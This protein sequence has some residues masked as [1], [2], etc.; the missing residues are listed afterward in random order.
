LRFARRRR[1]KGNGVIRFAVLACTFLA[2][3]AVGL[4]ASTA[5]AS[6]DPNTPTTTTATDCHAERTCPAADHSYVWYDE[7]G[8]GWDCATSDVEPAEDTRARVIVYEEISYTCYASGTAPVTT[9]TT[10]G[11][12]TTEETTTTAT[13]EPTT[14]ATVAPPPAPPAVPRTRRVKPAAKQP[15]PPVAPLPL[16]KPRSRPVLALPGDLN[17][18]PTAAGYV[19]PVYGP[20]S[21][22]DTYGAARADTGWHHG[23]DIFAPLG[24]PVLA[25][26]DGTVFSV[27]WNDVGGNRLWLRD[28]HGWQYYYAHLS[29]FTPQAKNGAHV[30][31]GTVLGFVGNTG[32]AAGTPYHLHFEIHPFSLLYMG[33]DGVVNPTRYLLAWRRLQDISLSPADARFAKAAG[34]ALS[35]SARAP[36][37]GAVLLQLS[38]IS[39]AS[40]LDRG[41]LERAYDARLRIDEALVHLRST[42]EGATPDPGP[43]RPPRRR[44]DATELGG[45][46]RAFGQ[47]MLSFAGPLIWDVVAQCESGGDWSADTGNG[48]FGGLQFLPG[49]WA[50]YGGYSFA[51][52][53]DKA[54][55]E[56]QIAI[57]ERT[58]ASEGWSAWPDCSSRLGLR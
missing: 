48:F 46:E 33:Y 39:T 2:L 4:V 7:A 30:K 34:W 42:L 35:V 31:A 32:D 5:V 11:E 53:A 20:V 57:A 55:R 47:D 41:S 16:P 49:T 52:S 13:V 29:A 28:E 12:T 24:A 8:R 54:S 26:A 3:A 6:D 18:K 19:F 23:D 25:V 50:R 9:T 17:V 58:L 38:D 37:P 36:Q 15:P 10:T 44:D 22:T 43:A 51:E 27:G 56:E 40:G 45:S 14:T 21:F 1:Y